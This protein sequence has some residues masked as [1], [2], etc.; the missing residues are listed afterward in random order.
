MLVFY[1]ERINDASKSPDV[2]QDWAAMENIM[3]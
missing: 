2:A 1:F 3:Q